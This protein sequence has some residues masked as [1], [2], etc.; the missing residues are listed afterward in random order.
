MIDA[1]QKKNRGQNMTRKKKIEPI[2]SL[3]N[4][5]KLT[6]QKSKPL[7]ALWRSDLTLAEFKILDTYLA[8]IDSH[9]PEKRV[10]MFKK[11]ELEE[12]LGVK[13]IKQKE[14]EERLKHLMG[15]VVEI[16]DKNGK[17]G[18]RLI[19]LFEEAVAEQ[20]EDGLWQVKMECT[21][22]AMKYIFNIE[23]L[24]YY[25]YKLRCITALS[26]R[27]TYIM[28]IYLEANRFRKSW[29]VDVEDL[30]QILKCDQEATYREYKRFNDL[31]LK[32]VQKEMH[33]K[34]EC[35]YKYEPIKKGRKVVAIRFTLESLND[36][37]DAE[38]IKEKELELTKIEAEPQAENWIEQYCKLCDGQFTTVEMDEFVQM[39]KQLPLKTMYAAMPDDDLNAIRGQY[40]ISKYAQYKTAA[41]RTQIKH[42]YGYFKKLIQADID[43]L[44]KQKNKNINPDS[45]TLPDWYEVKDSEKGT[46]EDV[47]KVLEL[48]KDILGE[49]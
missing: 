7:F 24:G 32:K 2:I 3:G 44:K 1:D 29:E 41:S 33:Q 31:I 11:G 19:T 27:Y 49:K 38:I 45:V 10:V 35:R 25:R 26:S 12:K 40:I 18:F 42:I 17:K 23:N 13:Q 34:T 21:Q 30:K 22:K 16:P 37:L 9:H 8:R 39:T 5:D 43:G 4:E 20:D 36:D 15:N 6:V 48:Q 47:K 14:L 28:F 46:D